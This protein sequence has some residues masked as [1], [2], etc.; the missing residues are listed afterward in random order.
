[1]ALFASIPASA[2]ES[3]EEWV[4][5]RRRQGSASSPPVRNFVSSCTISD[6]KSYFH[7]SQDSLYGSDEDAILYYYRNRSEEDSYTKKFQ[8]YSKTSSIE[9]LAG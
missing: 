9:D 3:E 6:T 5:I 7:V 8:T 4:T 1:M 2:L